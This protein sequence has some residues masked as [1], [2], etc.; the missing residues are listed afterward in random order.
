[1]MRSSNLHCA[2]RTEHMVEVSAGYI[3]LFVV[4]VLTHLPTVVFA[5]TSCPGI[6]VKILNI[7]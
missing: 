5:Q 6:H 1:M 7:V 3:A 4:L 2:L